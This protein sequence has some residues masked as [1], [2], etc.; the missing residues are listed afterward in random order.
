MEI[1]NK[2]LAILG[3]IYD[4]AM[5]G[6]EIEKEM[7]ETSMHEWTDIAFSSIYFLLKRLESKNL[8]SSKIEQNEKNQTRKIYSITKSGQQITK[9]KLKE[10]L[11]H[12][13]TTI[14]RIDL[15]MAYLN[16]L[17]PQEIKECL[18][19][20]Q[21]EIE[22]SIKCYQE[23]HN[24]LA[25]CECPN[26]RMQLADRPIKLLQAEQEWMQQFLKENY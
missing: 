18:E 26:N 14:W 12:H 20:Y 4:R 2:E 16:I 7:T 10:I 9:D 13:E 22:K 5:Y 17:N 24:F 25:G 3:M 15:G 6:Y 21:Q 8:I 19:Q 11:S 23:L 1:S